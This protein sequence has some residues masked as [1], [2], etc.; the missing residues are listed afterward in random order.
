LGSDFATDKAVSDEASS[1][2]LRMIIPI[3]IL[4]VATSAKHLFIQNHRKVWQM[5]QES[6]WMSELI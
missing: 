5:S 1:H 6:I 4:H 2:A 3:G